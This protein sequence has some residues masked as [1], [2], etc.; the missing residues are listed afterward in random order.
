MLMAEESFD[1]SVCG[2]WFCQCPEAEAGATEA[3][4]KILDALYGK[5]QPAAEERR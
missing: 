1:C 5:K 3:L 4:E 2:F